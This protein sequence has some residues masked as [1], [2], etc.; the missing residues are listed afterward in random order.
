[1][2]NTKLEVLYEDN[3]I[4]AVNKRPSDIVQ[5][6]KTGDKPLSDYVKDYIKDKYNKPGDVFLGTVHRIDRPVSGIVLFARTSKSLTRLNEMFRNKEVEK[7]YW[8]VVKQ[9]PSVENGTLIHYLIKNEEKN[10]SRAS[11]VEK[12]GALRSELHYQLIASSDNYHLLEINPQTGRHHQIRV[13]LASIG[14]PI[15]GDLKYGFARSNKDASIHLH[16]RKVRFMHPVKKEQI[17]IIANP[18]KEDALWND[19]LQKAD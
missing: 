14:C 11:L 18:P 16:A 8:A 5:G 4:I 7:T 15:K 3:H 13:Q 12:P 10:K 2:L 6:D 1:M 19:F 17:E 9:R